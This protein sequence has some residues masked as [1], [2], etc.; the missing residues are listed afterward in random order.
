MT[1]PRTLQEAVLYFSNPD[2]CVAYLAAKRW[3]KGT[4]CP[5]CGSDSVSAFNPNRRSWKCA[6]HHPK[7]E[8]SVKVG[9]IFEDS[10]IPLDKW[11]I[12]VWMLT[13]CKN[14]ISSYEVGR[15]LGVTQKTAW[16]MLHRVR[17]ALQDEAG[18]MLGGEV[19]VDETYIGGRARNMHAAKRRAK[20]SGT[21]GVDKVAVMGLLERHG[22]VRTRVV[23]NVRKPMLQSRVREQVATGS[24]VFTD[25]LQ[26]YDGLER[27]YV[28]Q[29]IDHAECYAK[30]NVH[31]NGLENYWSLLKRGIRGTYVSVEPFH[32]FRYLDEQ[33]FRFNNRED[34]DD[35]DR[36]N[37]A[38]SR[39]IG[40]RLTWDHLTGKAQDP[41]TNIN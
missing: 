13:N 26:S 5:V 37:L 3:P 15:A 20:I 8:F 30:E 35:G 29:V 19:E 16:F 38:I 2:N 41:E 7:R 21:G 28:H 22:R 14:G 27:E 31:T 23:A 11:L 4:I 32:L 1:E 40:K 25:A 17:L 39:I 24:Q 12:A 10:A 18:G 36:F 34:Y 6:K 33:A 9:T